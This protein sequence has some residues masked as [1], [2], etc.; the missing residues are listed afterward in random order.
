MNKKLIIMAV[1]TFLG[2]FFSSCKTQNLK[3]VYKNEVKEGLSGFDSETSKI[4]KKE[5]LTALPP[6]VQKYF[7]YA[8]VIGTEHVQNVK[9]VFEGRIRSNPEDKWMIFTSEQYNFFDNPV[10]AFY[11]DAKKMGIPANGLHLY[12]EGSAYMKVKL[13]GLFKVVDVSGPEMDQ[14]ETVTVLNDMFFFAPGALLQADIEWE[15]IDE[16]KVKAHYT[17]GDQ[18]VSAMI[19]FNENGSIK[20]FTSNDRYDLGSDQSFNKFPWYTPVE[21]YGE[22]RG[23]KFPVY[24]KTYYSR[25]DVEFCY[26]EFQLKDVQ[27]NVNPKNEIQ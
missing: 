17:L 23:R 2:G 7:E 9:I 19:E 22:I 13:A 4:I 14:S 26:G 27:Y 18:K 24:A 12:K 1:F 20:N 5:D 3:R 21:K 11:I 25:P 15:E 6:A 10:R 8:G 16:L